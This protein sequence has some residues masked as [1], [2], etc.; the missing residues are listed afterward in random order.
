MTRRPSDVTK[1]RLSRRG[2]VRAGGLGAAA[3]LGA[4]AV[5]RAAAQ[6]ATPV[7]GQEA[8]PL[9]PLLSD[10]PMWEAFGDRALVLAIDRGAD[11]GEC[12]A[13]V[14]RVGAGGV[15]DWHREWVATADRI[16]AI[17][18]ASAAAGHRVSAREAYWRA[19]NYYRSSYF[20]LYGAPTDPRLVAAF[21]KETATFLKGA[22]LSDIPIE[23]VEIP[24]EGKTL[25]AYFVTVDA[26]GTPRPTIVHT[27]GYDSTIQEMYFAHAP[28]AV[29]RGY[30]VLLFDGPGQGRNLIKD[31]V[32]I[33]PDW[34]NVVRP[35]IDYA[36]T[37]PEIAPK[38]IALGGW[39]FGGF[40]APRAAAFEHR[41]AALIADPGQ[42]DEGPAILARLPLTDAQKAAF[43]N[44]DAAALAPFEEWLKSPAAPAMLRWSLIQR[45]FWVNGVDSVYAYAV[46]L[47]R[48]QLSPVA[49]NIACPTFIS[50]AEDD[51]VAD[52]AP[53]LY[54]AL[55][56]PNKALVRFT[57][58][59]GAGM[60]TE[61]LARTLYDQ[62]MF[63][64][65][66]ATLGVAG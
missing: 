53:D 43:P 34:E 21:D 42:W 31:G 61:A 33:R 23:A 26:S 56:V 9:R 8:G 59:E 48:Y 5:D 55:T 40:L 30:N 54:A 7:A 28:A 36:L 13:T 27:N 25:P 17:G 4:A 64:W 2:A 19:C 12:V 46:D 65:L 44:I 41:L 6:S 50:K 49:K 22:A 51:S 47:F 52:Y 20:P 45:G 3:L 62:R 10:N 1:R 16:A 15:D 57:R 11:F 60:H 24:F 66:D 63:D 38:K 39:S 37:R 58:A 18:D 29:R 14:Q 32:H 35:V